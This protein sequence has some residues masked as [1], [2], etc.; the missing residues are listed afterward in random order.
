MSF[1]KINIIQKYYKQGIAIFSGNTLFSICNFIQASLIVSYLGLNEFG[2]LVLTQSIVMTVTSITRPQT[3]QSYIKFTTNICDKRN[4]ITTTSYIIDLIFGSVAILILVF[5][6]FSFKNTTIINNNSIAFIPYFLFSALLLNNGTSIGVI[7]SCNGFTIYSL[8][9]SVTSILR[10]LALFIILEKIPSLTNA[11]ICIVVTEFI[12]SICTICFAGYL[13]KKNNYKKI[14]VS[15]SE[16]I[17]YLKFSLWTN[18]QAILDVPVSHL[19]RILIGMIIDTDSVG[20]YQL[21]RRIGQF[22]GQ[23]IEPI[24]QL[25]LPNFVTNINKGNIQ[26]IRTE[27]TTMTKLV[28]PLCMITSISVYFT[29]SYWDHFLFSD[30]M[31]VWRN[32]LLIFMTFQSLAL[33]FSWLDITFLALGKM[34]ES[35]VISFFANTIFLILL[36]ILGYEFGIIGIIFAIGIQYFIYNGSK[37]LIM[38]RFWRNS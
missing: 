25:L 7:R 22:M 9:L 21:I 28:I 29:T 2:T 26:Q 17:K 13:L 38:R 20:I 5:I 1:L 32:E 36:Y 35:A 14:S 10:I 18:V 8:I 30:Q 27:T 6:V 37:L 34:K 3:W 24:N 16:R 31:F 4:K 33:A 12:F 11:I 23:L 15:I 19:D